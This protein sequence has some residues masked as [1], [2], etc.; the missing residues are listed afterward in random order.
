MKAMT[1]A[2]CIIAGVSAMS[3]EK[4]EIYNFKGKI[5][6]SKNSWEYLVA[7]SKKHSYVPSEGYYPNKGGKLV[8]PI[9][10]V[11]DGE[12]KFFKLTFTA[13]N[14]G[15]SYWVVYFYDK[16]NKPIVA[17]VYSSI[18]PAPRAQKYEVMVYGRHGMS[19][20]QPLFQS[21]EGVNVSD[22]NIEEVS[23]VETAEWC[24]E[25]YKTLPPLSYDPPADRLKLIP[26]SFEAMKSG[27][28]WRVVMLGDSIIN[29]TFNSN[30]QA[31]IKRHYPK[32][33]L[34]FICSV[35]GSTGC[36]YYQDP[37]QFKK[38]VTDLKPD[39]LIIG[40]ISQKNKSKPVAKV[41]KMAKEL[42]CE[43]MVM[44]GPMAPDWREFDENKPAASLSVQKW[45]GD[46]INKEIRE[47]AEAANVEFLDM[48]TIWHNY[49][50][51]SKKPWHWFHRDRVHANDRG[52][53]IIGR[54]LAG[55]LNK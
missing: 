5:D 41:I 24:D 10:K 28:K 47:V 32:S 1:T 55:Y 8:G 52:K 49:L 19:A 40:G 36:W 11:K 12:F 6:G 42:G 51:S 29:D 20:L 25:I 39:L 15:T 27:K 30:F 3:A 54:I 14:S 18:Y 48:Q 7:G 9:V 16:E 26:K 17:D 43:I 50:G 21:Q 53:Q 4:K 38:Y 37:E 2:I 13:K 23:P 22:L 35:R 31:L 44:T 45:P 34:E 46:P 33:N